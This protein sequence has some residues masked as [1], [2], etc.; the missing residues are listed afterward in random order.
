MINIHDYFSIDWK[1]TGDNLRDLMSD[2]V[3]EETLA[4]SMYVT[5]R[6]I[7]N[8]CSGKSHPSIDQLVLLAI[9][10]NVDILDI[11]ATK[12]EN[13]KCIERSDLCEIEELEKSL[14]IDSSSSKYEIQNELNFIHTVLKNEYAKKCF[15]INTLED[16]LICLPLFSLRDIRDF[17][18][19]IEG[20]WGKSKGQKYYRREKLKYLYDH[21][22]NKK[23]KKFVEF[24]KQYFLEKPFLETITNNSKLDYKHVKLNRGFEETQKIS[25]IYDEF[26]KE[27]KN[28]CNQLKLLDILQNLNEM[29]SY[30]DM[31]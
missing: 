21:I 4:K 14:D 15:P 2:T 17:L 22:E 1:A 9:F 11:L 20:N 16:F 27:Y 5:K 10:F 31:I 30:F 24:Y 19:R 25:E 8:W 29:K 18:Q 28:F 7:Y 13:N 3:S 26:K 23:A 6:T 12:G